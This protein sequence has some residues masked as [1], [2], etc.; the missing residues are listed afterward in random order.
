MKKAAVP[1]ILV[2]VVLLAV[3]VIA[4]AQQAK[5]IPRIGFLHSESRSSATSRIESFRQAFHERGYVEGQNV[6]IEYRYAEGKLDQLPIFA[7]EL[8]QLKVD[9][10]VGTG[11]P[12]IRAAEQATKTIPIVM[13][14][15]PDPVANG[16]VASLAKP[17]G[18]IT[19]LTQ[20]AEELSGKRL[21]LLRSRFRRFLVLG[22][23][24]IR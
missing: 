12:P 4:E 16:F 9:V 7:A 23:S 18:N 2:A 13:T 21:E 8:V 14:N 3:A 10:I 17:G 5:K 1:S 22:F 6:A 11:I 24:S 19:G 15:V 20:M